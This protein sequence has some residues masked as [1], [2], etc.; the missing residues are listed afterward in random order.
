MSG[1]DAP[2]VGEVVPYWYLWW[3]EHERGEDS[4]RKPRPCIVIART[5]GE[6]PMLAL[7]PITHTQPDRERTAVLIP[8]K[9]KNHL[10]LDRQ[11]S[12]VMCDEQNEFTWP[13]FDL[14]KTPRG[15]SSFGGVP[16]RFLDMIRIAHREARNRGALRSAPR[17]DDV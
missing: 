9:I 10:G 14:A 8:P 12:W 1:A 4:G 17:D 13:A 16:D 11:N 6:P 2:G 15:E 3:R 5:E 7:L